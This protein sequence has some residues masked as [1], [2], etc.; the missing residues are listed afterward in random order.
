MGSSAFKHEAKRQSIR[1]AFEHREDP[2]F[3]DFLQVLNRNDRLDLLRQI[4][5]AYRDLHDVLNK[6]VR[7]KVRTAV[8]LADDLR[9]VIRDRL[10][11]YFSLE[12]I[13]DERVEPDLLGGMVVQVGDR[14]LDTSVRTKLQGIRNQ[15]LA[16]GNYEIQS[17]RDRFSH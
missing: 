17:G 1:A 3:V 2:T 15:L 4:R 12:P 11:N 8:A 7:V 10:R 13:L 14:V 5:L 16:S 9:T 6:R